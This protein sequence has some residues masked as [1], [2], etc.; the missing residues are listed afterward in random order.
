MSDNIATLTQLNRNFEVEIN[1]PVPIAK[2]RTI[3]P[4]SVEW[5]KLTT[6]IIPS[7]LVPLVVG[8]SNLKA[9]L[10]LRKNAKIPKPSFLVAS[11]NIG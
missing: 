5:T 8:I 3:Q 2:A 10:K 4:V 1:L 7:Y 11:L 9:I 6:L